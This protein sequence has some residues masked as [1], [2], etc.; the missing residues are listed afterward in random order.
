MSTTNRWADAALTLSVDGERRAEI[1]QLAAR[2]PDVATLFTF[3]RDAE[4]RFET[5]RLRLE[6]R[7]WVTGGETVTIHELL[8]RHPGLARVTTIHPPAGTRRTTTSGS[9]TARRSGR[10]TPATGSGRSG[11]RDP[12]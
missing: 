12:A 6:E 9:P 10:G 11:R 3:M 4:L 5:L 2:L 8:L 7:T 1:A